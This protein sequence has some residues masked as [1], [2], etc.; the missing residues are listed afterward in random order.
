MARPFSLLAAA[1]LLGGA[2]LARA[3]PSGSVTLL[4]GQA[5]A[6]RAGVL[7]ALRAGSAVQSGDLVSTGPATRIEIGLP[8]GSSLR[9]GPTSKLRL[10]EAVFTGGG[11]KRFSG[12]LLFGRLWAKVAATLGGQSHFDIETDNAVAG[13]RGTIFRVDAG[14]DHAVL[15]RVYAGAV[16]VASANRLPRPSP[17]SGR[18]EVAGPREVDRAAY[19][20]LVSRAMELRVSPKGDLGEPA[21]FSDAD[22]AQDEW[23]SW[24]RNRDGQ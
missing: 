4:A 12:K 3:E 20:K 7:R 9:L 24:N 8:D 1:A 5:S 23:V 10:D 19:E 16:A 15:V 22:E 2:S 17:G 11:E 18:S 6:S 14:R 21:R 13:V